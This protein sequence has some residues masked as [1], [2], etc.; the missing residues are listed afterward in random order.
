MKKEL[1]RVA[2]I[3]HRINALAGTIKTEKRSMTDEEKREVKALES[4]RT[5]LMLRAR[6]SEIPDTDK[7]DVKK[8]TRAICDTGM[9]VEMRVRAEGAEAVAEG[10]QAALD[11]MLTTDIK[12]KAMMPLTIGDIVRPL[13]ENL[14]YDKIGIQLPTGCRGN[15][16]WP[17]VEAVEAQIAGEGIDVDASKIDLSKVATVTQ[18]LTVSVKATREA[19]FQSDGKLEQIIRELLPMAI[20][21]RLNQILTSREK[22]TENCTITGPFVGL[23]EESVDFTF[24]AL[25]KGKAALLKEGVKSAR[26]C[27]V[28]TEA[29]K[30]ELEATPIDA[31]S[32]V[33]TIVDDKMCG[34]P[35][36]CSS[37][38]GDDY[39]GLGD[40]TYQVCGQFGDF[41]FLVDPY[42]LAGQNAVRFILNADFGTAKLRDKAFKL[43]K[44]KP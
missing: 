44:R 38:I 10:A 11:T 41:Y 17:V 32:G 19:L 2:E 27:W 31:G 24:K 43:F 35:V 39:I 6:A 28:M 13:R 29:T 16:E 8:F 5:L 1:K 37:H 20:A 7:P 36:F 23:A 40:F 18:R 33:M 34:L 25:N 14:I 22:V 42:T 9:Q 21:E 12:D 30:A 4:E 26:M 3:D 15:Y